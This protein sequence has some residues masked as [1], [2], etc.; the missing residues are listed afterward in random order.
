MFESVL[1]DDAKATLALLNKSGLVRDA[2]LAGG[3]ALALHFGHR[4]SIDFDFFSPLAFDPIKLSKSLSGIGSFAE[5]VVK[6]TSLIG[7]F[8]GIKMSYFQYDYLLIDKTKPFLGI[9]VA[10]PHDIAAMKLVAITDRGTKKDFI[11]LYELTHQGIPF[12]EM[13]RLYDRKY[14]LFEANRFTLIKALSYLD[15]ADTDAMPEMI[16]PISWEEVKKFF[17]SEAMR[18]AK[19]YL[20]EYP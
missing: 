10:H 13:F 9:A 17:T 19:K 8:Q 20:E 1:S 7:T 6:G 12:D 16:R 3:S 14:K 15:E 11:D 5:E 18:L 2:Y 4:Y